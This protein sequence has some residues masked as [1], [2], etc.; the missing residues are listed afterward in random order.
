VEKKLMYRHRI[1]NNRSG[2]TLIEVILV[3]IVAG[4]LI[5][6][7]A[8]RL[9]PV[10]DTINVEDTMQEM[11]QLAIAMTGNPDLHNNGVRNDFGYIGDVGAMPPNLDALYTNPGYAT[12]NGPYVGNKIVQAADDYKKDAWQTDYVYSG[13][14]TITS[15]GSGS[16]IIRRLAASTDHLLLNSIA[17]NLF[18]L[19]GTPPGNAYKDSVVV[20]LTI[21]D[22]IGG[23][24]TKFGTVDIGGYFNFDSIPIGNHGMDIIY[25][26][27]DDT[28]RRFVSVL[29]NSAAYGEYFLA[30]NVWAASGSGSEMITKISGSDSLYAD[31]QGFYF[32]VEN[33]SGG[34]IDIGSATATWSSL[35]AYYRY[36]KWDG[37]IVVDENNPRLGSGDV[38]TFSSIQT[39]NDGESVRVDIDFFKTNPAGGSNIDVNNVTFTVD[40]SDGSSMTVTTGNCP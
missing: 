5:A 9:A 13:G 8:R 32:W 35:T 21:P 24:T 3:I 10:V 16:N 34:P 22:G 11:D 14:S 29:Q 19:D 31:C 23:I 28:L 25:F 38:A 33:N 39:I 37:T 1:Y 6:I 36:V 30:S 2:F 40:F 12:W 26:P 27:N 4:I 17:G 20:R 7:A 18:D 15:S